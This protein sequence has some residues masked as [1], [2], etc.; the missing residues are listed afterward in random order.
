MNRAAEVSI[1]IQVRETGATSALSAHVRL[2]RTRAGQCQRGDGD[3]FMSA[4]RL[5]GFH[6]DQGQLPE[7]NRSP[8][9]MRSWRL[10]VTCGR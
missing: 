10:I 8:E 5:L 3:C 4:A 7:T 2:R 9:L 1:P 6:D